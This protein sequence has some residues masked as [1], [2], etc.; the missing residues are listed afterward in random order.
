MSSSFLQL[1]HL[2]YFLSI[3]NAG[4]FSGA[5]AAIRVAQPALSQQM[6]A[7]ETELEM[8]LLHRSARGVRPTPEGE[9]FYRQA[10]AIIKEVE[11]LPGIVRS[12]ARVPEGAV[13]LGISSE[14]AVPWTSVF[15]AACRALLPTVHLHVVSGDFLRIS[16][17]IASRAIDICIMF[18]DMPVEGFAR[19]PLFHQS[20]CLVSPPGRGDAADH[21]SL[22]SL[23][24]SPLVLPVRSH[25]SRSALDRA[26]ENVGLIPNCIAE[27]DTL[28][29]AL[30]LVK[31]GL[32]S[33]IV[34]NGVLSDIPGNEDLRPI[35]IT[36]PIYV[37]ACLIS[38]G[39]VPLN[40]TAQAVSTVLAAKVQDVLR[41]G[42][43]SRG[44]GIGPA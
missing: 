38:S 5:A 26:F 2:R 14:I 19:Q 6:T 8:K 43:I 39:D 33:A 1:R 36:P 29:N 11:Q 12:A 41:T 40:S 9:A 37:T 4:S 7:L 30:G 13:R 32:A 10:L 28:H 15:M 25:A 22:E 21:V 18:E 42:P 3:V 35:A 20:L 31:A 27:M 34:P 16:P 17:L 23:A 44:I 24:E